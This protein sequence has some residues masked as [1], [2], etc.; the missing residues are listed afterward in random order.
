MS[1]LS[2]VEL[3]NFVG[4]EL[5]DIYGRNLG[6]VIGLLINEDGELE[7]VRIE[8]ADRSL[9]KYPSELLSFDMSGV[10]LIPSWRIEVDHVT[11]DIAIARKRIQA[12]DD[13]LKTGDVSQNIY[14]ELS[15][16]QK[17]SMNQMKERYELLLRKLTKKCEELRRQIDEMAKFLVDVKLEYKS[18]Q[19]EEKEYKVAY[20]AIQMSLNA[21]IA[22][23]KDLEGALARLTQS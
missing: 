21:A 6:R 9:A 13:L 8:M 20:N 16:A 17:D 2:E 15:E 5:K 10:V 19:I 22:E 23:K 12:L 1:Q 18:S 3:R 4:K 14:E 7:A 11:R